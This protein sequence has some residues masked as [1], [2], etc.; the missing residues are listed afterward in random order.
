MIRIMDEVQNQR[1]FLCLVIS[2]G[3]LLKGSI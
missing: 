2:M 1:V 3:F